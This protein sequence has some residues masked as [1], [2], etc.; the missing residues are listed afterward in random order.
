MTDVLGGRSAEIIK[1]L[2][3]SV[4]ILTTAGL[5][6]TSFELSGGTGENTNFH[7]SFKVFD[8]G[9]RSTGNQA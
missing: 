8:T 7:T 6:L 4:V 9:K 2:L 1:P 3:L 5:I